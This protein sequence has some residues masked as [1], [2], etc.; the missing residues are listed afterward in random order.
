[1]KR[2]LLTLCFVLLAVRAMAGHRVEVSPTPDMAAHDQLIEK[3][4]EQAIAL[5]VRAI[6]GVPLSPERLA[7]VT[8]LLIAERS[9]LILGYSEVPAAANATEGTIA[10]DVHTDTA[11][12]QRRLAETGVLFTA[13]SPRQYVLRLVGVDSSRTRRLEPLQE[14]SGLRPVP[15]SGPDA[16]VLELRQEPPGAWTGA[17]SQGTWNAT[18][19]AKTLDEVWWFLWKGYFSRAEGRMGDGALTVRVSGWLSSMGPMEFDRM[20]DDWKVEIGQK[21][22]TGVE[23]APTGLVGVWKIQARQ[24]E[25]LAARLRD[26]A[27]AQGLTVEIK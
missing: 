16:P 14:I 15:A 12:I 1:M 4:L 8:R 13:S 2:I 9:A 20:M 6:L 11:G 26:A 10:L 27:Q 3:G 25:A 19:T 24:R 17:L 7:A 21:A 22:L 5:D 23:M 18:R